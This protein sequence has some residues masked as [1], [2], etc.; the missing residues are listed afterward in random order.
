MTILTLFLKSICSL[1][2]TIIFP[3]LLKSW[4]RVKGSNTGTQQFENLVYVFL[5][6]QILKATTLLWLR[7]NQNPF[8]TQ[9]NGDDINYF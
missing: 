2:I 7:A 6:Y 4:L 8:T 3:R 1:G 5:L 9:I